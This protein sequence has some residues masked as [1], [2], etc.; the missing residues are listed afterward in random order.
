M[1][2]LNHTYAPAV[3][4]LRNLNLIHNLATYSIKSHFNNI[5]LSTP[6]SSHLY[7]HS[8]FYDENLYAHTISSMCSCLPAVDIPSLNNLQNNVR[9]VLFYR[10]NMDE[11]T[12]FIIGISSNDLDLSE[13]GGL[14]YR[15]ARLF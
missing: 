8:K 9:S 14:G 5:N 4:T 15:S 2:V 3:S 13:E 7:R 12:D 10:Y 6:T 11:P 1:N